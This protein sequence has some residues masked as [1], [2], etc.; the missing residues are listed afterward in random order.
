MHLA[1]VDHGHNGTKQISVLEVEGAFDAG[2]EEG[3]VKFPVLSSFST[4]V[5]DMFSNVSHQVSHPD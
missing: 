3:W 2:A 5:H 1:S 4:K